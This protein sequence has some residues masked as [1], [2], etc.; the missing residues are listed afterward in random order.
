MLHQRSDELSAK[1][2]VKIDNALLDDCK[3]KPTFV[4]VNANGNIDGV[5]LCL[6]N[7]KNMVKLN[8]K[9]PKHRVSELLWYLDNC[10]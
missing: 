1:L 10:R 5:A 9:Q 6:S 8:D 7:G 4:Y 3:G 2:N